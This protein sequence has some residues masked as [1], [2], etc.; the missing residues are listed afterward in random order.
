MK[1]KFLPVAMLVLM[2]GGGGFW[3]GMKYQQRK[4]PSTDFQFRG[5]AGRQNLPG[6]QTRAGAEVVRGEIIAQDETSITVKLPDESSKLVLISEKTTIN[7]A[8]E[9]SVADLE[10]GEQVMVFGQVNSDGSISATNIQLGLGVGFDR[11]PFQGDEPQ[12]DSP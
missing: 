8:T 11:T 2:V 6:A 12:R 10:T 5:A 9:G 7:K 3:T 4:Q 1:N